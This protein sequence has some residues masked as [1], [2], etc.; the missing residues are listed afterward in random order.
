MESFHHV[1]TVCKEIYRLKTLRSLIE[2]FM[3]FKWVNEKLNA[4]LPFS[5]DLK[6][7]QSQHEQMV[8]RV[9]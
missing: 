4:L 3:D 8:L 2:Y 9:S 1:Y 6:T 5:A 7:Q